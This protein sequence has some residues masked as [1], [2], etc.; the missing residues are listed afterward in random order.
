MAKFYLAISLK[1][2]DHLSPS[3]RSK[4]MAAISSKETKPELFV[5]KLI[6]TLGYRFRVNDKNLPGKPDIVFKGRQKA[7]F[8]H[9]CFWH[10][11]NNCKYASSPKTNLSFWEEKFTKNINRDKK[12]KSNLR[13]MGWQVLVVWQCELKKPETLSKKL[14]KFISR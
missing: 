14:I 11:H 7:I 8:V 12:V 10:R 3:E 13:L 6:Y 2:A 1:M 9:G 5:R 4:N